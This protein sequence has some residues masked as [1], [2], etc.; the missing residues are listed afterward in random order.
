MKHLL[1]ILLLTIANIGLAKCKL[2]VDNGNWSDGT[3]WDCG[4]V[5]ANIGDTMIIPTSMSVVVDINSPTYEFMRIEVYGTMKFSNGQKINMD[6]FGVVEIYTGGMLTGGNAGSR[7]NIGATTWWQGNDP[8]LLGPTT[9]SNNGTL[10]ITLI[11]FEAEKQ[12]NHICLTWDVASQLN[13]NYFTIYKSYDCYNWE[14]VVDISG[15]GTNN[16]LMNYRWYDDYIVYGTVYYKLRQTDYDGVYEEFQPI[17]VTIV[18][19]DARLEVISTINLLGVVVGQNYKG[20]IINIY[21]NGEIKKT[22]IN[23]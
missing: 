10:P 20:F 22:Y 1:I 18:D 2:I 19:P 7:L 9:I 4:Y 13:N 14:D 3:S 11:S 23:E 21:N 5:P 16:Q 6:E 17:S 8:P 15:G 12:N